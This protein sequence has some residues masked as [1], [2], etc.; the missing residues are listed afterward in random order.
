MRKGL[1]IPRHLRNEAS[2]F[3]PGRQNGQFRE[4]QGD[5]DITGDIIE[6]KLLRFKGVDLV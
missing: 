5:S 2:C 1:E 3:R 4:A 6:N